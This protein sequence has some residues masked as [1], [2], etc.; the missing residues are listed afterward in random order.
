MM[1]SKDEDM[2]AVAADA[3]EK[4]AKYGFVVVGVSGSPETVPF[5]YTVGLTGIGEPEL[6]LLG[7]IPVLRAKVVL[8]NLANRVLRDG[9]RFR[10]GDVPPE[11]L[12]GGYEVMI[13]GP[14]PAPAMSEYPPGLAGML[15][16]QQ[17]V[18]A[19]Q[20]VCQDRNHRYP[21]QTG[22]DMPSQPYLGG[23][24]G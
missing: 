2:A 23:G 16:G 24:R 8:D 6:M 20:L 11:V 3:W 4:I 14:V 17:A 15:Y 5:A 7:Q 21:W 9:Q 18:R 13:C 19:Y 10:P 22:Y 12:H 1:C